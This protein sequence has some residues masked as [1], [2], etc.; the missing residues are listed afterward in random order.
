MFCYPSSLTLDVFSTDLLTYIP[1]L[2]YFSSILHLCKY[3][4]Q[5]PGFSS[6]RLRRSFDSSLV[7]IPNIQ[8]ISKSCWLCLQTPSVWFLLSISAAT[9]FVEAVTIF[10]LD[11][12]HC[13]S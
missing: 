4:L 8:S 11:S 1:I 10:H 5:L 3:R 2:N 6:Q 7:L 13:N 9:T 12:A